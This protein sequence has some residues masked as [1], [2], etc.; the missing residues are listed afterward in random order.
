MKN[1]LLLLKKFFRFLKDKD[2]F[3]N[4]VEYVSKEEYFVNTFNG[5]LR[6]DF[7][8]VKDFLEE[9]HYMDLISHAFV[10]RRTR[11]GH[12]FWRVINN[13]WKKKIF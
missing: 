6:N 3:E 1:Q 7:S 13:E 11:E 2:V 5:L 4:Y 12:D 9:I 10:W 8:T